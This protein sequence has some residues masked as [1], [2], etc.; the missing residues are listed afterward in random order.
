LAGTQA[1]TTASRVAWWKSHVVPADLTTYAIGATMPD[2]A[3][4]ERAKKT[5]FDDT[6][7]CALAKDPMTIFADS[8]D[9]P[10]LR[11]SY[12]QL[13]A[14]SNGSELNDSQV[15]LQRTR[16][17]PKVSRAINPAQPDFKAYFLGVLGQDHWG[18]SFPVAFDQHNHKR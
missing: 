7:V 10:S 13:V 8:I 9:F 14:A 3:R 15:P 12:Y 4:K 5:L 17:W 11:S 18:L 2:I 16:F 6:G 1:L